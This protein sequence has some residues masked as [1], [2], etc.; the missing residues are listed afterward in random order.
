MACQRHSR[1]KYVHLYLGDADMALPERLEALGLY[2]TI[3]LQGRLHRLLW[4]LTR[5][6]PSTTRNS[7]E[8]VLGSDQGEH[9]LCAEQTLAD[10]PTAP[11]IHWPI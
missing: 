7:A 9:F 10:F 3:H 1:D 4:S 6:V 5:K 2:Y 11:M 8:L